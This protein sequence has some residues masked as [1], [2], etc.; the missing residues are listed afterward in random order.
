MP[1]V[2]E[3]AEAVKALAHSDWQFDRIA[4]RWEASSA[5]PDAS[6]VA[7]SAALFDAQP[8][9]EQYPLA[10]TRGRQRMP[11]GRR[12]QLRVAPGLVGLRVHDP[13]RA[14]Y[15]ANAALPTRAPRMVWP[16]ERHP[17]D[18]IR[19]EAAALNALWYADQYRA[20]RVAA[21]A[22]GDGFFAERVITCWSQRSRTRMQERVAEIDW[23]GLMAD[24]IP[25]MVTLTYPRDW[26]AVAPSGDA[27][28]RHLSLLRKR[29]ARA[30][31]RPLVGLWKLEFQERGAPH[32]HIFAVPPRGKAARQRGVLV[33]RR[34]ES[35]LSHT[36]ADIVN[37][38]DPLDRANHLLA[39]TGVDRAEGARY[40]DPRRA[41]VY[42]LKHSSKTADSKE[43]QHIVPAAW[44]E[45][46]CGPGRF[47]GI[48]GSVGARVY[49][50]EQRRHVR[51]EPVLPRAVRAVEID[52]ADFFTVKRLL[53]RWSKAQRRTRTVI[54]PRI[55]RATGELRYRPVRRRVVRFD[56]TR[57]VGGFLIVNDGPAFASQLARAVALRM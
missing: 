1:S 43:Y 45:P 50:P 16:D 47:W 32:V 30:W 4:A 26:L 20:E 36:W 13:A 42:F 28:K 40:T 2:V 35:W 19:G 33:R 24:G 41:A 6:M 21:A 29:F 5:Y 25:A 7:A 8:F 3:H 11:D 31:G 34:F 55:N 22:A 27:V 17:Y 52:G 44:R 53:R 57:L 51:T 49:R 56:Q 15:T 38:P 48:W 18:V 54:A 10:W 12:F 23:R 39:G 14:S 9:A 46:G 37:H